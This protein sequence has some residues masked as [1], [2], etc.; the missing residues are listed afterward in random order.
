M[1]NKASEHIN[2][3]H[4]QVNSIL[5]NKNILSPTPDTK[6]LLE[7][8]TELE[9]VQKEI[10]CLDTSY[11]KMAQEVEVLRSAIAQYEQEKVAYYRT[12]SKLVVQDVIMAAKSETGIQEVQ[13]TQSRHDVALQQHQSKLT[14]H[15]KKMNKLEADMKHKV[16]NERLISIEENLEALK[17]TQVQHSER[18]DTVDE[19]CEDLMSKMQ[20]DERNARRRSRTGSQLEEFIEPSREE[21]KQSLEEVRQNVSFIQLYEQAVHRPRFDSGVSITSTE[22]LQ[23]QFPDECP[24][25]SLPV[26]TPDSGFNSLAASRETSSSQLKPCDTLAPMNPI[27]EET[28]ES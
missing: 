24:T 25:S 16:N 4:I 14:A 27:S 26:T 6:Q 9:E 15:D 11:Q 21:L 5:T 28:T 12:I 23:L 18:I 8:K 3:A 17:A 20:M 22:S 10:K 7:I 13:E 19:K 2:R 1:P